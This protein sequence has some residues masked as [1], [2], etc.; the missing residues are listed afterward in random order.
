[1]R[2]L[3]GLLLTGA[4][5][6]ASSAEAQFPFGGKAG[7]APDVGALVGRMLAFDKNKDG[8]LTRDEVTDERLHRLFDRADADKD[9]FVTKQ[10]LTAYWTKEL[11][12]NDDPKGGFGPPGKGRGKGKG[13]SPGKDGP[14][15]FPF[16]GGPPR[17]GDVLPGFLQDVLEMTDKQKKQ[18]AE[19]QKEVDARL[20]K[21]LTEEQKKRLKEFGEGFGPPPF[22]GGDDDPPPSPRPRPAG[23]PKDAA[24]S[25]EAARA[26]VEKALPVLWKGIEGHTENR[27]CFTCHN[28]GAPLVAMETARKRGFDVPAKKMQEQLEFVSAF[29]ERHRERF[30]KGIGPGPLP[31]G[32]ETDN[33][34]YALFTLEMLGKEPDASTAAAVE[35]TLKRDRRRGY[36]FTPSPRPPSES[37]SFMTTA[38]AIRGVLKYGTAEQKGL[39]A[40]R[41]EKAREWLLKTRPRETEDRVFR[42]IGLKAASAADQ[43]VQQAVEDLV[44]TQRDDGG[45]GQTDAMASDAYATGS[46]LLALHLAGGMAADDPAYRRG[47]AYLVSTQKADG[48]WHVVTRSRPFQKYFESGFPHGKDQFISC[49]ATGWAAT[50]LALAFPI[51]AER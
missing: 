24:F 18:L 28:H 14:D 31:E 15:G 35:Y 20:E 22:G 40:E 19:L 9:G 42:L 34:G 25:Q 51:K 8:K 43:D 50:A 7:K 37:S 48:S 33:T 46:A 38:L 16:P 44:G 47:L 49:H 39:V 45:W 23:K 2:I 12:G 5:L 32:G 4:I 6:A 30:L 21:I 27:A 3:T 11:G 1:M 29:L 10:E 26:A 41:V 17:P 36:W 13:G